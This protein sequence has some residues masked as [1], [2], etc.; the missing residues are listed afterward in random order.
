MEPVTGRLLLC[1]RCRVQVVLCSRCDRGQVYCG[2][3]CAWQ[4]RRERQRE[5]G[6]RYQRSRAGRFAHAARARRYRQRRKIVTHQ[7]SAIAVAGDVLRA[8][9]MKAVEATVPVDAA[10]PTC[11]VCGVACAAAL[12][13]GF[14]RWGLRRVRGRPVRTNA[15][16]RD[17]HPP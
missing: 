15:R 16:V 14:L 3:P 4:A 11:S 8:D 10:A 1:V 17:D 13:Q 2:R 5:A 6:A 9:V 7:G 12:R